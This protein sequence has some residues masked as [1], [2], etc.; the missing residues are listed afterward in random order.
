[1]A[2]LQV[3]VPTPN[4]YTR[5]L[6]HGVGR[7]GTDAELRNNLR[8]IAA[9]LMAGWHDKY[10]PDLGGSTG[11]IFDVMTNEKFYLDGYNTTAKGDDRRLWFCSYIGFEKL[12]SK[13]AKENHPDC[14]G[15]IC[16]RMYNQDDKQ[17]EVDHHTIQIYF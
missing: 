6:L 1:M 11:E 5:T 12:T 14:H 16:M 8:L 13:W 2:V 3:F 15:Y 17:R 10:Q 7:A 4:I 9:I